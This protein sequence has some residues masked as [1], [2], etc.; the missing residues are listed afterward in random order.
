ME[1]LFMGKLVAKDIEK[2]LPEP[3]SYLK[4]S[5]RYTLSLCWPP[6]YTF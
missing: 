5:F 1:V 2:V 6:W 4:E 3:Q